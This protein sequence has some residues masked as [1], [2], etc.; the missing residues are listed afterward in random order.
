MNCP[1]RVDETLDRP[2]WNQSPPRL[3]AEMTTRQDLNGIAK[4]RLRRDH[5]ED[6]IAAGQEIGQVHPLDRT[7]SKAAIPSSSETPARV[8]SHGHR[9]SNF[10][11]QEPEEQGRRPGAIRAIGNVL[12]KFSKF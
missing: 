7:E 12:V 3:A 4:S 11:Q 2:G 10:S 6:E 9:S 5:R 8:T 1:S